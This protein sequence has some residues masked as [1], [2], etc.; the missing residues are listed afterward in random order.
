MAEQENWK[1][2]CQ[3]NVA[4]LRSGLQLAHPP[5]PMV[6][7]SYFLAIV[8]GEAVLNSEAHDAFVKD[9]ANIPIPSGESECKSVSPEYLEPRPSKSR[10][11]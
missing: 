1:W 11:V 10:T 2:L 8:V 9:P 5:L 7:S 3:V 4:H 6:D